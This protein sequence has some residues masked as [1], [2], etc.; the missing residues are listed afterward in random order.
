MSL[1]VRREEQIRPHGEEIGYYNLAFATQKVIHELTNLDKKMYRANRRGE[2]LG[3]GDDEICFYDALAQSSSA[4]KAMG[5]DYLKVIAAE[6]VTKV[7]GSVTIDWQY[8]ESARTRIRVLVRRILR[9][10]TTCPTYKPK[11]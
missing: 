9:R 2:G 8:R 4:V 11:P 6:L 3:L 7:R 1:T 10:Y 5:I